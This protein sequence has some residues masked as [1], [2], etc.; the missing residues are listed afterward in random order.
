M[1]GKGAGKGGCK[2]LYPVPFEDLYPISKAAGGVGEGTDPALDLA[3]PRHGTRQFWFGL[4]SLL[5]SWPWLAA[6]TGGPS[7]SDTT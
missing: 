6:E 3:F 4:K 5:P 7:K 1:I 2:L